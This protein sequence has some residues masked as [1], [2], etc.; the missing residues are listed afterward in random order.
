VTRWTN[1][2]YSSD[3]VGG[4]MI[5][6]FGFGIKD[7]EVSRKFIPFYPAGHTDYWNK[8]S[9]TASAAITNAL[10]LQSEIKA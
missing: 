8:D 9:D 6:S 10:H 3:F 7:I 1:I 2:Y 4:P 5:P